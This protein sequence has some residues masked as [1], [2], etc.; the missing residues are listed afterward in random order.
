MTELVGSLIVGIIVTFVV[1]IICT[2]LFIG[3]MGALVFIVA[4]LTKIF[5]E[6]F[7]NS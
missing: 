6:I 5:N 3:I 2:G 7:K 1:A 4:P